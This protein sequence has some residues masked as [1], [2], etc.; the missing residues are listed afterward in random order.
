MLSNINAQRG[1]NLIELMVGLTI[2]L[3]ILAGVLTVY[4]STIQSSSSTLKSI[5]LNQE[6]NAVMDLMVTDIARAGFWANATNQVSALESTPNP[7]MQADTDIQSSDGDQCL[8]FTYDYDLDGVV[9]QSRDEVRGYKLSGGT[10][11]TVKGGVTTADTS[12]CSSYDWESLTDASVSTITELSFVVN[13][14]CVNTTATATACGDA[15]AGQILSITREVVVTISASLTS[16]SSI[17][18]TVTDTVKV[19]ND[20]IEAIP[21]I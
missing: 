19:R 1:L 8:M 14:T 3:L 12:D 15:T 16:D 10:I 20:K 6:I 11:K 21:S 13:E 2:G 7:F 17:T 18:K 4:L 9:T 5:R